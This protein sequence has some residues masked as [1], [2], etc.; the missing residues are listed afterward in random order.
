M[1]YRAHGSPEQPRRT[2]E[3]PPII[4][5]EDVE[6]TARCVAAIRRRR[7][8]EVIFWQEKRA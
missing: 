2:F 5:I 8:G 6:H 7:L 4:C 1:M 3:T